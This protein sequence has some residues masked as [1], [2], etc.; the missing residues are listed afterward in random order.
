MNQRRLG[1]YELQE[2]LGR[3][4]VGETWQ[5]FDTLQRQYVAIKLI[6]VQ[7]EEFLAWLEHEGQALLGLSHPNIVHVRD[8][9]LAPNGNEAYV[10]MDYIEGSSL[11][12]YLDMTSHTGNIPSAS[13]IARLL[14]PVAESAAWRA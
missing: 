3:G 4:A 14:T 5:A 10:V 9:A 7:K 13:E 12:D 6:E 2:R 11:L 8:I 1:D